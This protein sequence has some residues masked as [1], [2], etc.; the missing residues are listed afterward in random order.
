MRFSEI[1]RLRLPSEM[2]MVELLGHMI[3]YGRDK[4]LVEE[5]RRRPIEEVQ[6]AR[7]E[8]NVQIGGMM[9]KLSEF[10]NR[11]RE[12]RKE[13]SRAKSEG[14]RQKIREEM[15]EPKAKMQW[16]WIETGEL[17]NKLYLLNKIRKEP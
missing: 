13:E 6:K 3:K 17:N 7:K 12:L 4:A 1:E 14:E 10:E 9:R 15:A 2:E 11:L 5:V 8:I 16:Y